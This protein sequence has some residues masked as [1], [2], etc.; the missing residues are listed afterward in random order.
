MLGLMTWTA[1]QIPRQSAPT[2]D[3]ELKMMEAWL[4]FHRQTLLSTC[5]GLTAE[6][7]RQ[8]P[9]PPSTMSLL[10]LVRHMTDVERGWFRRR[11]A[12][13]DIG[14]RYSSE[15]DPDG[16]FDNVEDADA[17]RDF[18]AYRE[19]VELARSVAAGRELDE[20]FYHER[21]EVVM[22]VRW[23][24]LHMIEEYARHNGHADL[25]R[26]RTDSATRF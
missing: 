7:L 15:A 12:G 4:E 9:A 13:E 14:F 17:E 23:V 1:P 24:Y 26:D 22:S 2:V 16:E 6:Q 19:E 8:R 11:I 3:G 20:T 18:A 10:G 25:L 21:R 5:S